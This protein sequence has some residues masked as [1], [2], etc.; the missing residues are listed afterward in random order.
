MITGIP[1][2]ETGDLAASVR[3]RGWWIMATAR[4]Q[5]GVPY[6]RFVFGGAYGG[7]QPPRPPNVPTGAIGQALVREI[8]RVI[9]R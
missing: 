1:I 8:E 3:A 4:N 6:G 5:A 9:F 7:A 2:G